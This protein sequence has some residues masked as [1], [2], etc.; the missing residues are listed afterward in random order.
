[1]CCALQEAAWEQM[2]KMLEAQIKASGGYV[3]PPPAGGEGT[4]SIPHPDYAAQS[5]D[6]AFHA[7]NNEGRKERCLHEP[8]LCASFCFCLL[9]TPTTF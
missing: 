2:R 6:Q 9:S 8:C 4:G 1:M 3:E 5:G 7:V